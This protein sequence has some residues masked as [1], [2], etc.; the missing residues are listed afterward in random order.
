MGHRVRVLHGREAA[1]RAV[2]RK[3]TAVG[4]RQG[5]R[6]RAPRAL[7]SEA[8]AGHERGVRGRRDA[9]AD[10]L[11]QHD[12]EHDGRGRGAERDLRSRRPHVRVVSREG[13]DRSALPAIR[14]RRRRALRD[15]RDAR[16]FGGRSTYR[17]TVQSCER[18]PGD[19]GRARA[20][21]L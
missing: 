1:P 5:R 9:A 7:G 8:G 20:T 14:A 21:D 10:E 18:V 19:G 13:R 16:P 2:H 11:P 17:E 4:Q 3:A 12:R 6:P 15:R